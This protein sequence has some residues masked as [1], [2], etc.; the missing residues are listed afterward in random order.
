MENDHYDVF[1]SYRRNGGKEVARSVKLALEQSLLK[2]FLDFDGI[3]EGRFDNR[4]KSAIEMSPT[5]LIILSPG[6]LDRCDDEEDWVR[7]EILYANHLGKDIIPVEVDKC[8][9]NE[10]ITTIPKDIAEIV[11]AHQF[12]VLDTEVLFKESI[13]KLLGRIR[14]NSKIEGRN[15]ESDE[16]RQYFFQQKG[17]HILDEIERQDVYKQY[18]YGNYSKAYSRESLF[19][20]MLDCVK[21][22]YAFHRALNCN[23]DKM[24]EDWLLSEWL[25]DTDKV[26]MEKLKIIAIT[27][28]DKTEQLSDMFSK[29]RIANG[30]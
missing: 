9:H 26:N 30:F 22:M 11:G 17:Y 15:M 4:I 20:R 2:V 23:V 24:N 12:S 6:A 8:Y 16:A 19:P 7:K 13:D 21:E 18:F 1:I 14:H 28:R 29:Y 10:K 25:I 27:R 3:E 5:F